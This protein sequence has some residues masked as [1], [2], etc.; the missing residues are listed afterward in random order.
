[1]R[2]KFLS[3]RVSIRTLQVAYVLPRMRETW[4]VCKYRAPLVIFLALHPD[5]TVCTGKQTALNN[6]PHII[7]NLQSTEYNE[8]FPTAL[9]M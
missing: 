6:N 9:L 7:L 5:N 1:M 2:E 4:V 8:T 3:M